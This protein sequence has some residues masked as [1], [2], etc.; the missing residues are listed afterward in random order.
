MR[1]KEDIALAATSA[2]SYERHW[3]GKKISWSA[4]GKLWYLLYGAV[5]YMDEVTLCYPQRNFNK[6]RIALGFKQGS[7]LIEMIEAAEAFRIVRNK[8]TNE[9]MAFMTPLVPDRFK[10]T[11]NQ[12]I[13][14]PAVENGVFYAKANAL[15]NKNDLDK[16]SENQQAHRRGINMKVLLAGNV[17]KFHTE[18]NIE[19][20]DRIVE[21]IKKA[22]YNPTYHRLYFG[23][24]N[25]HYMQKYKVTEW[26]SQEVLAY[27]LAKHLTKHMACRVGIENWPGEAILTWLKNYFGAKR[28]KYVITEAHEL[29]EQR[30]ASQG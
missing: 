26:K 16:I 21:G 1:Q 10:P 7:E 11:D 19:A 14:E 6:L 15:A 23:E 17:P 3:R 18:P 30:D 8:D 20:F 24:F 2:R 22:F 4:I 5:E 25:Y 28:L 27:Y 29:W 9:M 13:I 12:V